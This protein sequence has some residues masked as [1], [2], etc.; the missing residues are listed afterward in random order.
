MTSGRKGKGRRRW[1]RRAMT[2]CGDDDAE[3][4]EAVGVDDAA[5]SV[6]TCSLIHPLSWG[7]ESMSAVL[8]KRCRRTRVQ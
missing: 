3:L 7:V 8:R 5:I 1:F 4:Y 6:G 2:P